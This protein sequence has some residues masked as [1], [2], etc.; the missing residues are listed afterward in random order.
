MALIINNL[1]GDNVDWPTIISSTGAVI[2]GVVAILASFTQLRKTL[3][4]KKEEEKRGDVYKKLNEFYGPLLQL[5]KKSN[6]LIEE[7]HPLA[8]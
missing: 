1:P 5:R 6:L 7:S 8:Q 4:A 3:N 2:V